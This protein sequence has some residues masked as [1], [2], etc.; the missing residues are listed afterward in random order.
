M[1]KTYKILC[2]VFVL[3]LAIPIGIY[4]QL[5]YLG[6]WEYKVETFETVQEDF[7]KVADFCYDYLQEKDQTS[8]QWIAVSDGAHLFYNGQEIPID[9]S[10]Q[11][12]LQRVAQ[13]FPNKDAKLDVIRCYGK[14]VSFD[15]H[16]GLYSVVYS[17]QGKSAIKNL[18][19]LE[20]AKLKKI[21]QTWFHVSSAY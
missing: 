19:E 1:K 14:V 7:Q 5:F 11:N 3:L 4:A 12:S 8:Y 20:D 16:N 6:R 15:T 2:L 18:P 9:P 21:N 13:A 17:P 10:L